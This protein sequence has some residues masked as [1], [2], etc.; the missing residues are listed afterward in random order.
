MSWSR[1][2]ATGEGRGVDGVSDAS[3]VGDGLAATGEGRGVDGVS[4]ASEVGVGLAASFG[5]L[6]L[7]PPQAAASARRTRL[8]SAAA[9]ILQSRIIFTE[10]HI[11]Y[12]SRAIVGAK[13]AAQLRALHSEGPAAL[14]A[15]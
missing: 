5:P 15:A 6:S 4:D 9:G 12:P 1:S 11:H 14:V 10:F 13:P 7:S 2:A 8:P 3:G